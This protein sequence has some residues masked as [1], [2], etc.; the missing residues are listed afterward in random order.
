MSAEVDPEHLIWGVL[1]DLTSRSALAGAVSAITV[2]VMIFG[3]R[4]WSRRV[5]QRRQEAQHVILVT[6]SRGKSSTVRLLHAAFAEMGLSVYGKTTGTAAAELR[7]DG[8]ELPTYRIG[9]V[10]VLEMLHTINRAM[11]TQ[12]V[13]DVLVLECMAVSPDLIELISWKMVQPDIVVITNAQ[14]DH[15][16]EEGHTTTQIARSLATAIYP[17]CL[18]VTGETAPEPLD[19]I[20]KI[21]ADRGSRL[22]RTTPRHVPQVLLDSLPRAHPAN[23]ATVLAVCRECGIPQDVAVTGMAAA[24]RE[25]GE[26]EVWRRAMGPLMV[27]YTDFGAINDPESLI[28]ALQ[29]FDWPTPAE[30]PK[31]ALVTGR[32]DRPLRGLSFAGCLQPGI[33]DALLVGGGPVY[34]IRDSLIA[35]GWPPSRVATAVHFS[36]YPSVWLR[37]F[38]RLVNQCRPG[39]TEVM[40]VS[41]ENEHDAMAE[42]GRAFF[43]GGELIRGASTSP[44]TPRRDPDGGS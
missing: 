37:R 19:A 18:V 21:A 42:R 6:G 33:F 29:T 4:W 26:Q 23:V 44:P 11:S 34:A 40:L 20:G 36:W 2:L 7:C 30:V 43:H 3:W 14:L 31:I 16:E 27:T 9:Q 8:T 39:A 17:D 15:L 25:P 32:W 12:P 13:P 28:A 22:V 41:V 24:S 38:Q 35:Q 5:V 10:S 1:D